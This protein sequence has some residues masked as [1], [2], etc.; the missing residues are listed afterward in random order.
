[1]RSHFGAWC[2]V[3]APLVLAMDLRDG[4]ELDRVWPILSN[5]EAI[6][7]NQQWAGDSGRLHSQSTEQAALLNCGAGSVCS[8]AAWMVWTKALPP[9]EGGKPRAAE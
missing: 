1:M 8:H 5:T 4:A 2:V 6:A 9:A 3:S 7:V